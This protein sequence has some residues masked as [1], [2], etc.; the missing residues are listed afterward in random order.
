[1]SVDERIKNVMAN[2]FQL[3]PSEIHE[4]V[5]PDNLSQ[6]DSIKHMNLVV[7]LE[8]EFGVEFPSESIVQMSNFRLIS[9][10]VKETTAQA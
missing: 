4:D 1:M 6:W 7:S 8:E 5:S 9:L 2:V 10:I 3:Q